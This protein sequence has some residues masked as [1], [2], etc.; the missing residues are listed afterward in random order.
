MPRTI[1]AGLL[2]L[3][4]ILVAGCSR[5]QDD[6]QYVVRLGDQY[7]EQEELTALLSSL[8]FTEDSL[9]ARQQIIE[10]WLTSQLLYQEARRRGLR[11]DREVQRMLEE[12]ERSVLVSALLSEM[13]EEESPE[14]DDA[15]LASYYERNRER[16]RLRE[17]FVN[18]RYVA[19]SSQV[20]A[21][22]VR[23][24]LTS[25]DFDDARWETLLSRHAID[26]EES[27][28]LA[29]TYVA[30][31]RL[32]AANP[33]LRA[34][35]ARMSPGQVSAPIENEGSF[36]VLAL[37][38]RAQTGTIPELAWIH[39]EVQRR[40][41]IEARKQMYARQVQ[42]LRNEALAREDLDIR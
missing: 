35:L 3:V 11:S 38:D 23:T 34:A 24:E 10:Q 4:L 15:E 22:Q 9:E 1:L 30:E 42:R 31:G 21:D 28:A 14:F 17:P 27:R 33:A 8:P 6:G 12:N 19:T 25:S 37:V 40:L 5:G 39:D 2:S 20:A 13:Y 16:L 32:F 29:G 26:A 36:H 41:L 7:L 18:V